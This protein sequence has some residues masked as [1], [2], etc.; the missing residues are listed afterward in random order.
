MSKQLMINPEKCTG[1]RTCELICSYQR[2]KAFNPRHSAV[3]VTSCEEDAGWIP[4]MCPHCAEAHCV[5]ACPSEAMYR[6]EDGTVKV[7]VEKC[8]MCKLCVDAC[9]SGNV[10][11]CHLSERVIKCELCG[12]DPGCA[13]YCPAGAIVYAE[14]ETVA[15]EAAQ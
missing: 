2:D 7:D 5:E 4:S 15:K 9:P 12:G 8:T 6:A 1:C 10:S 14:K 11:F 3:T 13:K